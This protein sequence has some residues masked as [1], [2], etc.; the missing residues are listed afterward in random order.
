MMLLV[1]SIPLMVLAV[2]LA[3]LPLILMSF[4]DHR[5]HLADTP[6]RDHKARPLEFATVD[7]EADPIAA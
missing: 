3:V 6:A 1:I 4:A 2:A 7:E 5:S